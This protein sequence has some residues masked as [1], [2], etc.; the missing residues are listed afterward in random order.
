MAFFPAAG[1]RRAHEKQNPLPSPPGL[2]DVRR[3]PM[4]PPATQPTPASS[5]APAAAVPPVP[6]AAPAGGSLFNRRTFDLLSRGPFA[7]YIAGDSISMVGL[8]MQTFAQGWVMTGLTSS[9]LWLGTVTFASSVPMLA[10]SM[11]GGS[12]A[13]RHDKRRIIIVA[14]SVQVILA[15]AV[16]WLVMTHQIHIW[17]LIT[18]S[19]LLGITA[20][21][22]MPAT[23]ALVP[24]LVDKEHISTAIA[25][26]RSVFHGSRLIGPAVAG[27]LI[28]ILGQASAFYANALS[29]LPSIAAIAS[30][31]PRPRG[32]DEEEE[33]RTSGMKAGIVYVRQDKPTLAMLGLMTANALWIFPFLGVM[34][35]LYA[36]DVIHLDS[37]HTG[38]LMA[39]SGAGAVVASACILLV[40]RPHRLPW[41]VAG[42]AVIAVSMSGLALAQNF[43]VAIASLAALGAGTSF[44]YGLANTTIQERAPGPLRGRVSA[45][46]MLSFVGV[47]PFTSLVVTAL[48]DRIGLRTAMLAGGAGYALSSL[49]IF[50]GPGRRMNDLPP[51]LTAAVPM[52]A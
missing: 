29:F 12:V 42:T 20:A 34:M 24:E 6:S 8:W 30:I 47:M 26:D 1:K 51:A 21:F 52:Q 19:F 40:P 16:G 10:L 31:Q 4:S 27:W 7:R 45:L 22:E 9:A 32:S 14:Q 48:A 23:N 39:V 5:E 43:W 18:A 13:D 46:A 11:Y 36:R 35:P 28:G 2:A 38:W 41:M 25:V 17:H 37:T 33:Q 49:L 15:A 50:G 44:N 3:S